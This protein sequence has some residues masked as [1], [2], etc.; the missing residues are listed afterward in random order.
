MIT[1]RKSP[2]IVYLFLFSPTY[3]LDSPL[4]SPSAEYQWSS[5]QW[6]WKCLANE[7]YNS[8]CALREYIVYDFWVGADFYD[9]RAQFALEHE[10]ENVHWHPFVNCQL[11]FWKC[12]YKQ[13][14][15][16]YYF[17]NENGISENENYTWKSQYQKYKI[18]I[19]III[20]WWWM[21][22]TNLL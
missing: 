12:L 1:C 9:L 14:I 13:L 6:P 19:I 21:Q 17:F 22:K 20:K 18:I 10:L 2:N 5:R 7:T 3:A 4:L 11:W 15:R 8:L 16:I